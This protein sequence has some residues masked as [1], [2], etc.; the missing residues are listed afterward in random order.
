MHRLVVAPVELLALRHALLDAEHLV[1][2]LDRGRQLLVAGRAAHL[3][4]QRPGHLST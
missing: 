4:C 1:P 2:E 3:V